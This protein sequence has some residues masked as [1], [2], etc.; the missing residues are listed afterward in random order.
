MLQILC[1]G[2]FKD[3]SRP[4]SG[5][6]GLFKNICQSRTF[7]GFSIKYKD[8][9]RPCKPW[10]QLLFDGCLVLTSPPKKPKLHIE[11]ISTWSEA[12]S[13]YCL[14]IVL[15][16]PRHWK[17]LLQYQLLILLTDQ[18]VSTQ[19]HAVQFPLSWLVCLLSPQFLGWSKQAP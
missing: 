3:F 19:Q 4:S 15:Y 9:S 6:Q 17:D 1:W 5:I 11:D 12:F 18:L 16:F 10:P 13:V 7:Q 8:F 2:K 14:I